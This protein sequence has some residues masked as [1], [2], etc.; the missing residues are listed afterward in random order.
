ML[1]STHRPV[2][3]PSPSRRASALAPPTTR[4]SSAT[5]ELLLQFPEISLEVPALGL[6]PKPIDPPSVAHLSSM[7]L[8]SEAIAR[9]LASSASAAAGASLGV[10][11]KE[12]LGS[13]K[14][15]V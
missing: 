10:S 3:L 9:D 7:S 2:C 4:P 14:R 6:A 5:H 1:S 13:R 11:A 12:G 8:I 15:H